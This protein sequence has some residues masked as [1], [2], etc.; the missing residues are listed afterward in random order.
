MRSVRTEN[1]MVEMKNIHIF[2]PILFNPTK[3]NARRRC[4]RP[5][6]RGHLYLDWIPDE[7]NEIEM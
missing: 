4:R 6:I 2:D 1:S 7:K 5:L 3:N